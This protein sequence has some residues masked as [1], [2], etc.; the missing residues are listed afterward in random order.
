MDYQATDSPAIAET[1]EPELRKRAESGAIR[2]VQKDLALLGEESV[3]ASA[4]IRCVADQGGPTW[5]LHDIIAINAKG[6]DTGIF[7][8]DTMLR[9]ASQLGLDVVA[10]D[11]CLASPGTAEAVKAETAE[12][13]ALG[14]EAGPAVIVRQGDT[15]VARFTGTVDPAAVLKAI[16]GV[17]E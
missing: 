15:E 3:T 6:A 14:I 10:F 8:T 9:V 5:L 4:A 13:V 12:G 11:A 16:D 7:V 17:K 1:L 2:V